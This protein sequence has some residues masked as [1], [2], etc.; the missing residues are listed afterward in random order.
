[1]FLHLF[2]DGSIFNEEKNDGIKER[3]DHR[4]LSGD[5]WIFQRDILKVRL[6]SKQAIACSAVLSAIAGFRGRYISH[7]MCHFR[8]IVATGHLFLFKDL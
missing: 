6:A 8:V 5:H 1:M 7:N 4:I 2:N 3:K